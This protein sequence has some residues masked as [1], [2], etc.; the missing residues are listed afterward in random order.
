MILQI[1]SANWFSDT[2]RHKF[3]LSKATHNLVVILLWAFLVYNSVLLVLMYATIILDIVALF[4]LLS[5]EK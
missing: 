1:N 3:M 4:D 2:K 5:I